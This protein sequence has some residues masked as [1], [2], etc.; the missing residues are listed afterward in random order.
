[1]SLSE[2]N[3]NSIPHDSSSSKSSSKK[4][5]HQN[6]LRNLIQSI[7]KN[8][9]QTDRS[10][11]RE[12]SRGQNPSPDRNRQKP[13]RKGSSLGHSFSRD[14]QQH[15]SQDRSRRDSSP[16]RHRQRHRPSYSKD[17]HRHSPPDH[18]QKSSSL[19]K[20]QSD[21]NLSSTAPDQSQRNYVNIQHHHSQESQQQQ[22][23]GSSQLNHDYEQK[24]KGASSLRANAQTS[25]QEPNQTL[26]DQAELTTLKTQNL[27]GQPVFM[28]VLPTPSGQPV[29][30]HLHPYPTHYPS[31]QHILPQPEEQFKHDSMTFN[32]KRDPPQ[33]HVININTH[34]ENQQAEKHSTLQIQDHPDNP[35]FTNLN[36]REPAENHVIVIKPSFPKRKKSHAKLSDQNSKSQQKSI[37]PNASTLQT[38][39]TDQNRNPLQQSSS[40]H[41]NIPL[42]PN[43]SANANPGPNVSQPFDHFKLDDVDLV[44][45]VAITTINHSAKVEEFPSLWQQNMEQNANEILALINV[46]KLDPKNTAELIIKH[47]RIVQ[48]LVGNDVTILSEIEIEMAEIEQKFLKNLPTVAASTARKLKIEF[49]FMR[50]FKKSL[51]LLTERVYRNDNKEYAQMNWLG[52]LDFKIGSVL[53]MMARNSE[54][55]FSDIANWVINLTKLENHI[56]LVDLAILLTLPNSIQKNF[57]NLAKP[58]KIQHLFDIIDKDEFLAQFNLIWINLWTDP[59]HLHLI[60]TKIGKNVSVDVV[61]RLGE[62]FKANIAK[63]KAHH[64]SGFLRGLN[65]LAPKYNRM[66]HRRV[67]L[68]LRWIMSLQEFDTISVPKLVEA[69]TNGIAYLDGCINLM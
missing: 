26:P 39:S 35:F 41:H 68:E 42:Q 25:S 22:Q 20:N 33:H 9:R 23:S 12:Y 69:K 6:D 46:H 8:G 54:K 30:V 52:L 27:H 32:Q 65:Q 31:E 57:T 10:P 62:I 47:I 51:I 19:S 36:K 40:D 14:A 18:N 44:I 49:L 3:S 16:D 38:N 5:L 67:F 11:R 28:S 34:P 50:L 15:S 37:D 56:P 66:V 24:K 43:I 2:K 63:L 29:N 45:F 4:N 64:S 13:Y 1:M 55:P 60:R 61:S 53:V 21:R 17:Q 59:N 7:R 48:N 58:T